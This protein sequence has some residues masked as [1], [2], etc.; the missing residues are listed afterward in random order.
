MLGRNEIDQI[1]R[2]SK[3]PSGP[4]ITLNDTLTEGEL[5]KLREAAIEYADKNNKQLS[6]IDEKDIYFIAQK[7]DFKKFIFHD[8]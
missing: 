6:E 1:L 5:K 4:F 8:K 7:L 2:N 3:P